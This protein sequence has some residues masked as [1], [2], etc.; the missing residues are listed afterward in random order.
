MRPV[1][2]RL[3]DGSPMHPP[4]LLL[5]GLDSEFQFESVSLFSNCSLVSVLA[6][7]KAADVT[8]A[9]GWGGEVG[10]PSCGFLLSLIKQCKDGLKQKLKDN[11][12]SV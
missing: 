11:F 7:C 4:D 12:I 5:N 6:L 10:A 9:V 3:T 2:A 1:D 8:Q